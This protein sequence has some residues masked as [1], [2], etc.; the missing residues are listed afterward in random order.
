MFGNSFQEADF[1]KFTVFTIFNRDSIGCNT[2]HQQ[3]SWPESWVG[4]FS[5]IPMDQNS[6]VWWALVSVVGFFSGSIW[7]VEFCC[8]LLKSLKWGKMI[9]L[10]KFFCWPGK[11]KETTANSNSIHDSWECL[12]IGSQLNYLDFCLLAGVT[13][14]NLLSNYPLGKRKMATECLKY[15]RYSNGNA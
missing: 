4:S 1:W 2:L 15:Y 9:K 3:I 6:S 11:T 13:S 5:P 14:P 12:K 7:C 8:S 10:C